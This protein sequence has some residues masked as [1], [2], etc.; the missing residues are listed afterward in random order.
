MTAIQDDLRTNRDNTQV[1]MIAKPPQ[2]TGDRYDNITKWIRRFEEYAVFAGWNNARKCQVVPVLLSDKVKTWYYNLTPAVQANWAQLQRDL[3]ARWGAAAVT[4][5]WEK[6]SML[7]YKQ[8]RNESVAEYSREIIKRMDMFDIREPER[9]NTFIKGLRK[10]LQ[11][12]VCEG[13]V[14]NQDEAERR[15][16]QKEAQEKNLKEEEEMDEIVAR[17][18]DRKLIE[19]VFTFMADKQPQLTAQQERQ[20]PEQQSR[21]RPE[22]NSNVQ[23]RRNVNGPPRRCWR[24]NQTGHRQEEC[25]A[26]KVRCFNC[27]EFGHTKAVCHAR[28]PQGPPRNGRNFNPAVHMYNAQRF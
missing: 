15:A 16:L 6:Q 2:F 8:G 27:S 14:Q 21:P 9:R 12:Y 3:T 28:Q 7:E 18:R 1:G 13:N 24:C 26:Q 4:P 10:S 23:P 17:G 20:F 25:W 22:Y 5:L 19:Q 11:I